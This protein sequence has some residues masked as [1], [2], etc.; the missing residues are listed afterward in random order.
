[1]ID[2]NSEIMIKINPKQSQIK[3]R[4]LHTAAPCRL[5]SQIMKI[6]DNNSEIMKNDNPEQ[7]QIKHRQLHT[8]APCRWRSQ[9]MKYNR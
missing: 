3:H 4:Q 7:F 2:N 6:I 8:A 9:I 1:M 5:R